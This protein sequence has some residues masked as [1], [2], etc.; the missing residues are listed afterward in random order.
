[1]S[2]NSFSEA[3]KFTAPTNE[4][5]TGSDV[6][7][8]GTSAEHEAPEQ[9][10]RTF[11]QE[12]LDKIVQERLA[13]ERRKIEREQ[14]EAAQQRPVHTQAPQPD[15][16]KTAEEYLEA[17]SD[18]K[19]DQKIAQRK[20][21]E[22]QQTVDSSFDDRMDTARTKYGAEFDA[23]LNAPGWYC[24]QVATQAIKESELGPEI[25]LHLASNPEESKRIW[26]MNPVS[27][28]R[29]IGKIE[30]KLAA[31]PPVKKVSSAPEPITPIGA[32]SST[33]TYSTSDPRSTKVLSPSEWI[34]ARNKE[35][36]AKR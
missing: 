22:Q 25:A 26:D 9:E 1:M 11:T 14:R 32:K 20:H 33:P 31:N 16:F 27:Q 29:E 35:L 36:R 34:E 15:Q 23:K 17:V 12:E 6:A 30:A 24:S 18:W 3:V 7:N 10:P 8:P 21:Q 4:Q 28:I 19:A 5:T 2:D 13:K